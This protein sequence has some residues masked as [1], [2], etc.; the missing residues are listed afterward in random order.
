VPSHTP[1]LREATE[2]FPPVL[3]EASPRLPPAGYRL[4]S[5]IDGDTIYDI[6]SGID[7]LA[8]Q[9]STTIDLAACLESCRSAGAEAALEFGPGAALSRMA[10]ALFPDGGARAVEEVPRAGRSSDVAATG[11]GLIA[12]FNGKTQAKT[13]S[14]QHEEAV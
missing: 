4:L 9:I 14:R 8:R 7:K 3:C 10:S 12:V 6:D 2:R 5:G 13:L 1:L 11:D